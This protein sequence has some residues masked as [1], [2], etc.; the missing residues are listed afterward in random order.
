[1]QVARSRFSAQVLVSSVDLP[2]PRRWQ[3]AALRN[4]A[5]GNAVYTWGASGETAEKQGVLVSKGGKTVYLRCTGALT[6]ELGPD[7]LDNAGVTANGEDFEF[8]D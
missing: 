2:D 4:G 1:M 7:W 8:P 6:R 5:D 3:L